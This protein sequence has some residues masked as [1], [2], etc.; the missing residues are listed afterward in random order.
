MQYMPKKYLLQGQ[1][2]SQG[3]NLLQTIVLKN[4]RIIHE[5]LNALL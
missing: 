3:R 1:G 4:K 2:R 5:Y